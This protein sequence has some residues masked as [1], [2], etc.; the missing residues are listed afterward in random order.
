MGEKIIKFVAEIRRGM[1][2]AMVVAPDRAYI[3]PAANGFLTD[4]SNLNKDARAVGRGLKKQ[5]KQY[6][7]GKPS[8]QR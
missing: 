3:R 1:G 6:A 2:Q 7:N 5:V 4:H 8:H